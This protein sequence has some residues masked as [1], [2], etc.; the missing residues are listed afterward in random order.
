M[1]AAQGQRD[2]EE[3]AALVVA[4]VGTDGAVVHVDNHLAEVQ[5]DARAVD[6]Q[7]AGVATLIE[8]VEDV[9]QVVAV[10]PHAVVGHLECGLLA[11]GGQADVD[12]SAVVAVLEGVGEQVGNDLVELAAVDPHGQLVETLVGEGEADVALLGVVLEHLVDALYEADEVGLFAM[13]LHLLL[14][15]LADVENLVHQVE[16]AGGVVLYGG[17]VALGVGLLLADAALQVGQRRHDERQR[18][19][20]V[21]CGVDKELHLLLVQLL[22]G[23]AAVGH[24]D[25]GGEAGQQQEVNE[26]GRQAA[27]PRCTDG[28]DNHL[29]GRVVALSCRGTHGYAIG[30]GQQMAE[31]DVVLA[32][33]IRR[34]VGV[35][36]PV[37]VG[38]VHGVVEVHQRE[39]EGDGVVQ[40]AQREVAAL[41]DGLVCDL[42]AV[43][44]GAGADG[45]VAD[46][47]G[48]EVDGAG[49]GFLRHDVAGREDGKA[50]VGA[51]VDHVAVG[52]QAHAVDILLGG[53]SVAV[54]VAYEG[55][56]LRVILPDAHRGGAPDVAVVGLHDVVDGLVAQLVAAGEDVYPAALM[57]VEI[58]SAVGADDDIAVAQL[59]DGET[60]DAVEQLVPAVGQEAAGGGVVAGDA[61][62]GAHPDDAV[63]VGRHAHDPVVAEVAHLRGVAAHVA[64]VLQLTRLR[65][66]D[67]EAP[68]EGGD[69]DVA[70]VVAGHV[71][72]AVTLETDL[73]L[74][75]AGGGIVGK[76]TVVGAY[77]VALVLV[78]EDELDGI[79]S[80]GMGHDMA[81]TV[82]AVDANALKGT[83]DDATVALADR[84]HRR[85]GVDLL[86]AEVP[87]LELHGLLGYQYQALALQAYP[88][89]AAAVGEDAPDGGR[90]HVDAIEVDVV[91]LQAVAAPGD[92]IQAAA[93]RTYVYIINGVHADAAEDD[94]LARQR[95]H[96]DGVIDQLAATI[97]NDAVDADYQHLARTL[98]KADDLAIGL[99][100]MQLVTRAHEDTIVETRLPETAIRILIHAA[101]VA[102]MTLSSITPD[103]AQA[104]VAVNDIGAIARRAH[105]HAAIGKLGQ[106]C[107]TGKVAVR[108]SI[109]HETGG[110]LVETVKTVD[111]SHP[112]TTLTVAKQTDSAVVAN[113]PRVVLVVQE[114]LEA[115]AVETVQ[116]VVGSY[117]DEAVLVLTEAGDETTGEKAG[118]NHVTCLC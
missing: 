93:S 101:E 6:M 64:E 19:P 106:A 5:A 80:R 111:G 69:V 34:P 33:G 9:L 102:V 74:R 17:H 72:E 94:L 51:E 75:T 39:A 22:I 50:V 47:E 8:A 58:E 42:H 27:V 68:R 35:V 32:D 29:L 24:E 21:V 86:H 31:R 114:G 99:V 45:N 112:H 116:T 118:G 37:L 104:V 83:P 81:L 13:Q 49:S 12:G 84:G 95:T 92:A 53:Q 79:G 40:I 91:A 96:V 57:V 56:L 2:G 3:G 109:M 115:I 26:V 100:L 60:D 70:L 15:Y 78:A 98:G 108:K 76:Q 105:H 10:E 18:R 46:I 59:T 25:I 52:M 1:V 55:L 63:A 62:G 23:T 14:V 38:G 110:S 67:A 66:V 90:V 65:I 87:A 107:D 103:F 7:A 41:A 85:R 30:A 11:V 88:E 16:D 4:V 89:V 113:G 73:Q 97:G 117:P 36:N 43:E 82:E 71:V 20:D 44:D 54:D 61:R 28:N 48:R 77:P